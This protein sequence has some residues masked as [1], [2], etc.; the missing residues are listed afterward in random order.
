MESI[1]KLESPELLLQNFF[2]RIKC[3]VSFIAAS[4]QEA[5]PLVLLFDIRLLVKENVNSRVLVVHVLILVSGFD[6]MQQ[7]A[8]FLAEGVFHIWVHVLNQDSFL[9]WDVCLVN[10]V[11]IA[12]I[13]KG[14][15]EHADLN[16]VQDLETHRVF[17]VVL[18]VGP[19]VL[20]WSDQKH[21][22]VDDYENDGGSLE[23]LVYFR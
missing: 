10:P 13:V 12:V 15:N 17:Y 5:A 18:A 2:V 23:S 7:H 11:V 8:G 19:D 21:A 14:Q 6:A 4:L 3:L 22:K 9:L 20:R 16:E 1:K